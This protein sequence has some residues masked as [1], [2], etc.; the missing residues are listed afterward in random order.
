[1][2]VAMADLRTA[3]HRLSALVLAGLVAACAV[4][5]SEVAEDLEFRINS[6]HRVFAIG[7]RVVADHYI[8]PVSAESLAM[9][10]LRGLGALDPALTVNREGDTVV[11]SSAGVGLAR[12]AAPEAD[13]SHAWAALTARMSVSSRAVSPAVAE[14]GAERLYEAVFDGALANLDTFSRYAGAEEARRD[15][16]RRDGYGGIGLSLK[17]VGGTA[18][19]TRLVAG[20]PAA[21]AGIRAGDRITHVAGAPVGELNTKAVAGRLRG[22]PGSK[23]L[24]VVERL[25][26]ADPWSVRLE[27]T[28]IVPDTVERRRVGDVLYIAVKGFNQDTAGNVAAA[29]YAEIENGNPQPAGLVL[30]LRGNPGGLLKQAV[31]VADLFLGTG[32]IVATRSRHPDSLQI[33]DAGGRDLTE[34][35]PLVVMV[36]GRSASAAE[37][38][39]AALQDQGRAIVVGTSSFGKGTVQTVVPLPNDGEI[40]LTWSRLVPPSGYVLHGRGV[41]PAVC[42]SGMTGDEAEVIRRLVA[43]TPAAAGLGRDAECPAESRSAELDRGIA[44]RIAGDGALYARML[45]RAPSVAAATPHSP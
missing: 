26:R 45:G 41:R 15:R 40:T 14:A 25:G 33:Y 43:S 3:V 19:V 13:D 44:V 24:L 16:A 35:L 1:M 4:P 18:L 17:F 37:I 32:R 28:H 2:I 42:T 38:V 36:D 10:G 20:G 11:L 34:G 12:H 23:V 6:A 39:A 22:K 29:L 30:D 5:R 7:Y 9:E 8:E 21:L 31:E 27:R